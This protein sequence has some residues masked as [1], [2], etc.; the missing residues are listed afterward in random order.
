MAGVTDSTPVIV[1][2]AS[3]GTERIAPPAPGA[4]VLG[5]TAL[6]EAQA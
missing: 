2:M 6:L 1:E 5:R 3:G 4:I